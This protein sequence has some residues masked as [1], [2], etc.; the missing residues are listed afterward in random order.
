M[1]AVVAVARAALKEGTYFPSEGRPEALGDG[2]LIERRGRH[3]FRV[4]ERFEVGQQRYSELRHRNHFF[5]RGAVA[6]YLKHY[7]TLGLG[8]LSVDP[9]L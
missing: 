6:R 7:G 3:R 9:L 2:A 5:L 4:Y 1:S 8:G